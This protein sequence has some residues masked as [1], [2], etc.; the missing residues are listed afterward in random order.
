MRRLFSCLR[1]LWLVCDTNLFSKR[2][3]KVFLL[4]SPDEFQSFP[5]ISCENRDKA[6][7]DDWR[8]GE[9]IVVVQKY[10]VCQWTIQEARSGIIP[11]TFALHFVPQTTIELRLRTIPVICFSS[12]CTCNHSFDR[13][14]IVFSIHQK[15]KA[16]ENLSVLSGCSYKP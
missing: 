3:A 1:L 5:R 16:I 4:T 13:G 12:S 11:D 2:E 14:Q 8:M 7:F 6:F 9:N 10:H 15:S